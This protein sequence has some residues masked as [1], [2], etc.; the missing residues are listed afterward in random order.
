MGKLVVTEFI[1]L[2]GVIEEPRW[3]FEFNR[4]E[5]GDKFKGDELRAAD[6][7]LLGRI[8]YQGFAQAWPSMANDWFGEKMNDMP[9]YVVSNTL[10][11]D[12]ADWTNSTVIR[13]EVPG[14]IAQVKA[15]VTGD[16]LV[17][18]SARLVRTLAEHDLVD[19]YRLMFFPIVLGGGKRL[20]AEGTA[21]TVLRLLD[22]KP[23]GPDGVFI[24]TYE[25]VR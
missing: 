20:F 21:R 15:Q 18:G 24:L 7:Q 11:D 2:D 19:E 6:A 3:T 9:K 8:T 4:G 5:E 13:D 16:V 14:Q 1:S 23:V 22:S 25:P 17:A 12:E 10:S